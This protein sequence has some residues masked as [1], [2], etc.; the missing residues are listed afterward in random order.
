[1]NPGAHRGA[2][3]TEKAPNRATCEFPT[4][5]ELLINLKTAKALGLSEYRPTLLARADEVIDDPLPS[6]HGM[7]LHLL[8]AGFRTNL[9]IR[10][11]RFHGE[12]SATIMIG[13]GRCR[14]CS[15]TSSVGPCTV[16]GTVKPSVVVG[17][18]ASTPADVDPQVSALDPA[19]LL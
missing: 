18:T 1:M 10:N 8:T 9:P 16:R 6:A 11:V 5:I 17:G 13:S 14:C 2:F 4:N 12:G 19:R 15:I 3:L 7:L